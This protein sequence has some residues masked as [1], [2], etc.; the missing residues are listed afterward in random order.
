MG[1][2][3]ICVPSREPFLVSKVIEQ[4]NEKLWN[5]ESKQKEPSEKAWRLREA[6]RDSIVSPKRWIVQVSY[7]AD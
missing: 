3:S 1:L 7:S 4:L 2:G 5:L 6:L